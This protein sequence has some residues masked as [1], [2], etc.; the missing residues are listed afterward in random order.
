MKQYLRHLGF[1]TLLAVTQPG[2]QSTRPSIANDALVRKNA[3]AAIA[4]V[5]VG[6]QAEEMLAKL[7]PAATTSPAFKKTGNRSVRY[8]FGFGP[9]YQVWVDV[10][11]KRDAPPLGP[12]LPNGV[13]T[14]VGSL[15]PRIKWRFKWEDSNELQ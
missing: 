10:V 8:C 12:A 1:V 14:A 6:M 3:V 13:V 5:R 9:D 4:K 2:C 15:E 7:I 11:N